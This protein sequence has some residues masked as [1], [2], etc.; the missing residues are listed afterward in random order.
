MATQKELLYR[1]LDAAESYKAHG[2]A[3]REKIEAHL[4]Q[5]KKAQ[6]K[7]HQKLEAVTERI[8]DPTDGL[9]VSTNKNTEWRKLM[10]ERFEE[11]AREQ[12]ESARI[13]DEIYRWKGTIDKAMWVVFGSIVGLLV[14]IIFFP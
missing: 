5:M 8:T 1:V 2:V 9:I 11:M 3:E 6:A 4:V 13:L 14:K 10:S 7:T 12:R